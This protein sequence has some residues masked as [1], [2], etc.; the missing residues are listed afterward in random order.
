MLNFFRDPR[1]RWQ[2]SAKH[3]LSNIYF[4][5]RKKNIVKNIGGDLPRGMAD[6]RQKFQNMMAEICRTRGRSPSNATRTKDADGLCFFTKK[7]ARV[8][9]IADSNKCDL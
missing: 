9:N 5:V 2:I 6:L 7:R 3:L 4:Y 1:L 8:P